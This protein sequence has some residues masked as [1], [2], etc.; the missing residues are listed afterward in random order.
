MPLLNYCFSEF[1]QK[2]DLKI[3]CILL[4]K[5]AFVSES[6]T[7]QTL[8]IGSYV[9]FWKK[10][11]LHKMFV[12]SKTIWTVYLSASVLLSPCSA[13]SLEAGNASQQKL[14]TRK[15]TVIGNLCRRQA[16]T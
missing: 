15:R 1:T 8:S 7:L 13:G 5:M 9:Y 4:R 14:R 11:H 16:E 10:V 2:S 3:G 6:P 12:F